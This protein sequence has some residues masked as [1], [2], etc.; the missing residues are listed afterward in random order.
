MR[1]GRGI[2][3]WFFLCVVLAA[4]GASPASRAALTPLLSSAADGPTILIVDDATKGDLSVGMALRQVASWSLTRGRIVT[5]APADLAAA[6]QSERPAAVVALRTSRSKDEHASFATRGLD[7]KPLLQ[8]LSLLVDD[9]GEPLV[10]DGA[11]ALPSTPAGVQ[12]A[13]LS[14]VIK[15]GGTVPAAHGRGCSAT[16]C[17]RCSSPTG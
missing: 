4:L 9:K 16:P 5:A 6:L 10:E 8:S 12:A 7:A 1:K 3:A 17:T 13:R 2:G 11:D 15:N 14:L